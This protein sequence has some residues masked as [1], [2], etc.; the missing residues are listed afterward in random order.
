MVAHADARHCGLRVVHDGHLLV[1]EVDDDG[2]GIPGDH[3]VGVGQ[4]SMR[5]RAE[6]LGGSLMVMTGRSGRGTMVRAVL[7]CSLTQCSQVSPPPDP[8]IAQ[9][10]PGQEC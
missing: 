9:A 5:E 1:V 8:T 7:P 3:R 6:E 2:R 10:A 4:E